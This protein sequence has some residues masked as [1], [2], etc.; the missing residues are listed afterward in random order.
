MSSR[1]SVPPVTRRSYVA[2]SAFNTGLFNYSYNFDAIL[3]K[4]VG[5]LTLNPNATALNCP[6]GRILN[7]NGKK[8]NPADGNFRGANDGVLKYM[9]GVYDPISGLNGF[10]DPNSPLFGLQN[11]DKPIYLTE[12]SVDP[13][14][15]LGN[16]VLTNGPIETTSTLRAGTSVVAGTSL[17]TGTSI[18]AGTYLASRQINVPLYNLGG[19]AVPY[20]ILN[21]SADVFIDSTAGNIFVI[22]APAGSELGN[23]YVY[24]NPSPLIPG[25]VA[26][27]NGSLM[28]LIF[29]NGADRNVTVNFSGTVV[30]RTSNTLVLPDG[31]PSPTVSNIM[32]AGANNFAIELNRSGAMA[33]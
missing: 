15:F 18:T 23:I 21:S 28:T 8:L 9:V 5:S 16:G 14:D 24:F 10:I 1:Q 29:V 11:T 20:N 4:E 27:V 26:P 3:L 33:L 25:D 13:V 30:K 32:F 17:S 31:A 22:T 19:S 6:K 2:L 7:E 12:Q